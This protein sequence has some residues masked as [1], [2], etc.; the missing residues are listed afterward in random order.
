MQPNYRAESRQ[1]RSRP[2]HGVRIDLGG[3]TIVMV[4]VCT[5]RRDP[6]LASPE[7]HDALRTIWQQADAWSVGCYMIMPD[8]VHLFSSPSDLNISLRA[9]VS[10]WKRK[11]SCLHLEGTGPWQ[12]DYWDTRLRAS[13]KYHDKWEYVTQNPVRKGLVDSSSDWPFQGILNVLRW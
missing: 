8:H 7:V 1:S 6:W 5:K 11:F 10:H 13:E 4:T 3:P 9:W 2:T 12:R